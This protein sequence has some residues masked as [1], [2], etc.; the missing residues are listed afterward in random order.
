MIISYY[1]CVIQI[2]PATSKGGISTNLLNKHFLGK[3]IN[4][5]TNRTRERHKPKG[6]NYK[7]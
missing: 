3:F 5:R 7:Y 1:A 4:A 6:S 2:F